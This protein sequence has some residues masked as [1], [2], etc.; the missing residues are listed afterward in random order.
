M[1]LVGP[2]PDRIEFSN[3]LSER[4]PAYSQRYIVKPGVIGWSQLNCDEEVL[5]DSVRRLEYDLY[6]AGHISP[7]L[8]AIIV[9]HWIKVA[10]NQLRL[11]P[12]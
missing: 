5:P 11:R 9:L 12:I 4:I 8:D 7:V 10:L 1:S 3:I 2:E 6:Y